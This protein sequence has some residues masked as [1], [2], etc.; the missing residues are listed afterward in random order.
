MAYRN[1]VVTRAINI[2]V[3][4]QQLVLGN[5]DMCVPMEDINCL[6]LEHD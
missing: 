4:N 5:D 2:S 1:I 3:H 6:V